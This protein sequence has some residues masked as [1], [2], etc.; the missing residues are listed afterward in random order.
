ME[1]LVVIGPYTPPMK[2]SIEKYLPQGID[3][4]YI[5]SYEEY[6]ALED[7]DY[8]LLRTLRMDEVHIAPLKKAK[9]IQRWGAGYDTIDLEAAAKKG[10]QVAVAPGVNAQSVAEHT[11][12]LA[13]A[14]CRNLI[15]QARAFAAGEDKRSALSA[16]ALCI[17]GKTVGILGMGNI[18]RR[19]AG[20]AKAFG[21][22]IVYYDL[23]RMKPEQEQAM[24]VTYAG[25]DDVLAQA[26]ILCLHLPLVESTRHFV[27]AENIAKMRDG[28]VL[29][30][31]ARGELVDEQALADALRSGK[32][33]A[34]GLDE[35]NEAVADSPFANMDNVICT[36]HIGGS[37]IDLNDT[38]AK[39]C[40]E[41]L[42]TT[43]RGE[44]IEVPRLVNGK[45]LD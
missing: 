27:C 21:A 4:R 39:I 25:I 24:G 10:I 2:A 36:P 22:D 1:K 28:V 35:L 17:N 40:M 9:L 3:L 37:T 20:M 6:G 30:N 43:A 38:M 45:Y 14:A 26:Q 12:L 33:A 31:T 13:L 18:G 41:N 19:V 34:A 32:I 42:M 15:P 29:I 11:I 5:T 44:R 23:F 16:G 8:I 7:A